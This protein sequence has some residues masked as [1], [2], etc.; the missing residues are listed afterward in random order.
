MRPGELLGLQKSDRKG[1]VIHVQRSLN[2][3]GEVTGGKNDNARRQVVLSSLAQECRERQAASVGTEEMFP[4]ASQ[5]MYNS[6]L[7]K[8]CKYHGIT[9]VTPYG[10]RHTFVS[11]VKT[12]PEG[13][14]K[15]LVGHSVQMD[16]FGIYGHA[17][18]SD[19][20]EVQ[21]AIDRRFLELLKGIK[22][23]H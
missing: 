13:M 1:N 23:T 20:S 16:T 5:T 11:I 14:V 6:H 22:N 21:V 7:K 4:M 19:Q 3:M 17:L 8:Y 18:S 12:L 10:L 15:E 2:E 9:P